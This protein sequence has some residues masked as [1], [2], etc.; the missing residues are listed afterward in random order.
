M[1][2]LLFMVALEAS[3]NVSFFLFF[4]LF[5]RNKEALSFF[6]D[7]RSAKTVS[8][9]R[10]SKILE[11]H[12]KG[13]MMTIDEAINNL[14]AADTIDMLLHVGKSHTRFKGFDPQVFLVSH[15][16]LCGKPSYSTPQGLR[17]PS[18]FGKSQNP[19]W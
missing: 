7:L 12:V 15:H 19:L 9:L 18:L 6:E 4:S 2:Y 10:E 5:E 16:T 3:T 1:S 14:D 11:N 13:V 17:S 8:E